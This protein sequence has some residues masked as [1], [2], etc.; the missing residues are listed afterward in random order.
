MFFGGKKDAIS[1][2]PPLIPKELSIWFIV[3]LQYLVATCFEHKV[4][5]LPDVE[6]QMVVDNDRGFLLHTLTGSILITHKHSKATLNLTSTIFFFLLKRLKRSG[7][8][9]VQQQ[10]DTSH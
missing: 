7:N 10:K 1:S 4:I 8:N 3:L 9:S 6:L 2:F 5:C